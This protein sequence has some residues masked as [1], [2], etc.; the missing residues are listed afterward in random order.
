MESRATAHPFAASARSFRVGLGHENDRSSLDLFVAYGLHAS[1]AAEGLDRGLDDSEEYAG[2]GDEAFR[3]LPVLLVE[4]HA[5]LKVANAS[6]VAVA[7]EV[8]HLR[9]EHAEIA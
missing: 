1:M 2:C 9:F 8:G 6:A 3:A 7:N 4:F 5:P